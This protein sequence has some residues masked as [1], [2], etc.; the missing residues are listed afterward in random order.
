MLNSLANHGFLPHDGRDID[1][2]TTIAALEDAL[3]VDRSLAEF[4]HSQAVTTVLNSDGS[5]TF[6]LDDLSNHGILEHDA[7]L[8]FVFAIP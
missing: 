2:D 4:L 3:N 1:E 6:S 8:R 5:N 7:S